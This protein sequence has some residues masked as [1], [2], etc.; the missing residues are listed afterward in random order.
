MKKSGKSDDAAAAMKKG[1]LPLS[2]SSP[3]SSTHNQGHRFSLAM[4]SSSSS[5]SKASRDDPAKIFK[6][7]DENIIGKSSVFLGPYGRRKGRPHKL[8]IVYYR[9]RLRNNRIYNAYRTGCRAG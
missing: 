9:D 5:S 8:I 6:L 1:S 3:A 7:I 2:S 4:S